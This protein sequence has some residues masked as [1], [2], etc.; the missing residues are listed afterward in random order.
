MLCANGNDLSLSVQS[1]RDMQ[2]LVKEW[3]RWVE[4]VLLDWLIIDIGLAVW[5]K[6]IGAGVASH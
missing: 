3:L 5:Q 6:R 4:N 1:V 2:R